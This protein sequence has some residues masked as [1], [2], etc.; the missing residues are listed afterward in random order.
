MKTFRQAALALVLVG[1]VSTAQAGIKASAIHTSF[2]SSR[3][4]DQTLVTLDA[5]GMTALSFTLGS[6]GKKILTFSA[7][8][9]VD[10]PAGDALSWLDL[11]I[12]VNG[13][14]VAPT[15]GN[16]DAFCSASG[17][18]GPYQYVRASI[19]I[20]IQGLAG[21]NY[22]QVKARGNYLAR[23]MYFYNSTLVVLD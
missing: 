19:T 8:C 11:D 12:L 23:G 15:V 9:S 21:T 3:S 22:V 1:A 16:D 18:S 20:P 14:V 10:G 4:A 7:I 17:K 13:V 2:W 5:S 6:A